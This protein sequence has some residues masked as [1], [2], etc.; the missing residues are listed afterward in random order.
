MPWLLVGCGRVSFHAEPVDAAV[1][2]GMEAGTDAAS[3]EVDGG[4]DASAS[5][6]AAADT[7]ASVD[8]GSTVDAMSVDTSASV[9]ASMSVDAAASVDAAV[10]VDA[11]TAVDAA[12]ARDAGDL[13]AYCNGRIPRTDNAYLPYAECIAELD[14][15]RTA[16]NA[17][18][19]CA[20][21]GYTVVTTGVG[22]TQACNDGGGMTG[23]RQ[24]VCLPA[25]AIPSGFA[26]I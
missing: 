26:P 20:V 1:L 25:A 22:G 15:A 4:A 11:S 9:D 23:L 18:P 17:D 3:L 6:D 5:L 21:C 2:R 13:T 12:A 10:S 24:W 16:C 14:A 19:L 8:A 7:A